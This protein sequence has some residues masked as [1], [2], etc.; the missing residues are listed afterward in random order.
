ML[1]PEKKATCDYCHQITKWVG[2]DECGEGGRIGMFL[3]EDDWMA[4]PDCDG[5]GWVPECPA[6]GWKG[7]NPL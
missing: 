1:P 7:D 6:C 2:C 5:R 4:C 3:D